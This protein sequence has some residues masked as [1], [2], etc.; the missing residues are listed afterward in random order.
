[1]THVAIHDHFDKVLADF[2]GELVAEVTSDDG[3][4]ARWIEITLY[5]IDNGGWAVHRSSR[6]VLYHRIDTSCRTPKQARPG[7][8][9]TAARLLGDAEPCAKCRPSERDAMDPDAQVR[10]EIPRDN[11]H[12]LDNAQ[13]MVNDLTMDRRTG[14]PYWSQPVVELLVQAGLKHP[15]ILALIPQS[16]VVR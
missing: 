6:S 9:S 4:R 1:M 12:L 8:R 5:R 16:G 2:E 11:V 10:I 3:E 7:V 14:T 13:Q 15:E